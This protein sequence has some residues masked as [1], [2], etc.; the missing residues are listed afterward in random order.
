MPNQ[1]KRDSQDA[2][3]TLSSVF[4]PLE[5]AVLDVL[6]QRPESVS[7][8]T[9][10]H[11]F[12]QVAYTTLMTTLDRL[13]KKTALI[14]SKQGRAFFYQTRLTRQQAQSS[15]AARIFTDLLGGDGGARLVLSSFVDAVSQRDE[16]LLDELEELVRQRR[17]E[18]AEK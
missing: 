18:G 15:V 11:D 9:L 13:Y 2:K 14:R 12:P 5:L 1:I 10:Q 7:V 3:A 4:G 16:L 17:A 6:W 8:K